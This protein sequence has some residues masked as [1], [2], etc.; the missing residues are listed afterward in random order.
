MIRRSPLPR[1]TKPIA[2][3]SEKKLKAN[4]GRLYS[5]ITSPK[6]AIRKENPDA[7]RKRRLRNQKRMRSP[8]YLSARAGAMERSGGRCEFIIW[9]IPKFEAGRDGVVREYGRYTERCEETERLQFHE[10]RYPKTRFVTRD[11]GEMLCP[12]HHRLKES[13][14]LHKIGRRSFS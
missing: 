11:D 6:K 10:I 4:G 14:K 12:P 13:R 5:T 1:S 7:T 8:E 3:A 9:N 2:R